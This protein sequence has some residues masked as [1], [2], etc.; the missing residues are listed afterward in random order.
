MG[1]SYFLAQLGKNFTSFGKFAKKFETRSIVF[2][3]GYQ[4]GVQASNLV[5]KQ[6]V[7]TFDNL[8]AKRPVQIAD[9]FGP[10]GFSWIGRNE[11]WFHDSLLLCPVS[12][13][14]PAN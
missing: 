7:Y 10:A 6:T 3:V 11:Y 14:T 8:I 2:S 9:G 12:V 5:G 1:G 13:P 4:S